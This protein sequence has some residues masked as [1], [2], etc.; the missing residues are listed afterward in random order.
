MGLGAVHGD[1]SVGELPGLAQLQRVQLDLRAGGDGF[2]GHER[3][4]EIRCAAHHAVVF[5][6]HGVVTRSEL[7]GDVPAQ[8]LAAGNVVFCQ[9]HLAA[10]QVGVGN[11]LRIGHL[12]RQAE[13]DQYRGMGVHDG[14]QI[15]AQL[16]DVPV[17]GQLHRR[18]VRADDGAVAL[19]LHDVRA[20][21]VSLVHARGRDPDVAVFVS[22]GKVAAG[23]RGHA[24]FVDARHD[25]DQLV[26]RVQKFK[27]HRVNLLCSICTP[28]YTWII[29]C[30][31]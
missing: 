14:V 5:H 7:V 20:G 6:Q 1:L 17:E 19:H 31:C 10:D 29:T 30:A 26:C 13:G 28:A 23:G 24:V 25:H 27:V 4:V 22:D 2:K 18:L 9:R 11:Q 8:L 21:Q 15:R 3:P 12:A 16:V